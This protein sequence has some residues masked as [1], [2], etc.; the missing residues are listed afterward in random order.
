MAV[1]PAFEA[2]QQDVIQTH[3]RRPLLR[4]LKT[5]VEDQAMTGA[6]LSMSAKRAPKVTVLPWE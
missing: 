5:F 4:K 3:R 1:D 2:D 6:M